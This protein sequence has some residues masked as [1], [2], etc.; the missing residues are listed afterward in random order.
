[1]NRVLGYCLSSLASDTF[2]SSK[3]T[4]VL[5]DL[6]EQL[7]VV[8]EFRI[9]LDGGQN[10][11]INNAIDLREELEFL[12]IKDYVLDLG[13]IIKVRKTLDNAKT[14][15][16]FLA[17]QDEDF[18]YVF[19]LLQS[20]KFDKQIP[21]EIDRIIDERGEVKSSASER[22][23]K[24]RR[25]ILKVRGSLGKVFA[26]Q[27]KVYRGKK[28][29]TDNNET[30]RNGRRVLS[31]LSEH[32]RAIQGII[33]GMSESGRITYIEPED[34]VFQSNELVELENDE[35]HE[36]LKIL[37]EM[38]G[39]LRGKKHIL[40]FYQ[41]TLAEVDLYTAKAKYAIR[42]HGGL[43]K[44]SHNPEIRLINARHP[45]LLDLFKGRSKS[46]VPLNL[47]LNTKERIMVISGPNAGGKS[48]CLKTVGLLQMMLQSGL[49]IPADSTSV[50]G[51]FD[52]IFCE[53]GDSQSIEDELSTYSSHL[54]SMTDFIEQAGNSSLFLIDEFGTGTDPKFGGPLAQ[55]ILEELAT[56]G[57]FGLVT[58]HYSH[59]KK[60]A[61]SNEC[62]VNGAMV[63]DEENLSPTYRLET[64][65]PGSSYTFFIAAKSGLSEKL[66]DRARELSDSGDVKVE[67][68]LNQLESQKETVQKQEERLAL[69]DQDL[70]RMMRRY[71]KSIHEL[72][73]QKKQLKYQL[74]VKKLEE[75]TLAE[76][77]IRDL[78]KSLKK[79][80]NTQL[81]AQ[82]KLQQLVAERE[83]LTGETKEIH[84]EILVKELDVPIEVGMTVRLL[85][86]DN[87]G[88]VEEIRGKKAV[89][90]FGSIRTTSLLADLVPL[91]VEKAAPVKKP[92]TKNVN[93]ESAEI[94]HELDIRG[95]RR[96]EAM[97]QIEIFVDG[98][99]VNDIQKFRIIHG[100]GTGVIQRT[101]WKML[102]DYREVE[103][104]EFEDSKLGGHGATVVE[105]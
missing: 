70:K 87:A 100:R 104:F 5:S 102:R 88:T 96:E 105:L 44:L 37:K 22:L 10:I 24:I 19:S 56:S 73:E 36:I 98:A 33:H 71:E 9:I 49:L 27:L 1:M 25:S 8:E 46:A 101:V 61:T 89:V 17:N 32:K 6:Q 85:D 23:T 20:Q 65:K 26:K 74:K 47:H 62:I 79:E 91:N 15:F 7:S 66:I 13:S 28:Y 103:K 35:R 60:L 95:L 11:P 94:Q 54:K 59:L 99:I 81:A 45:L 80:K 67:N 4:I 38:C 42:V 51:V 53:I 31:V 2:R 50:M 55:V 97:R 72:E 92:A 76:S 34:A 64:G 93:Y 16:A 14:V 57:S 90:T 75:L 18:P 41:H 39:F 58:T 48:V 52:R 29:L 30:M 43:P 3:P 68:L 40:E 78:L 69:E 21:A 82:K 86:R 63:F 84:R 77:N 12:E 83:S